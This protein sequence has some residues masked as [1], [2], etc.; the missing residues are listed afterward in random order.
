MTK[1]QCSSPGRSDRRVP[2]VVSVDATTAR[3][4]NTNARRTSGTILLDY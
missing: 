1:M 3:R 4:N 2:V